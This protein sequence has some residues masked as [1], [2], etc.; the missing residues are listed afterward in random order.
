MYEITTIGGGLHADGAAGAAGAAF[1]RPL[2]IG[3]LP[4]VFDHITPPVLIG[5]GAGLVV[6]LVLGALLFG[7]RRV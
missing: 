6:G 7:G 1:R 4:P 3:G 5:V 2:T